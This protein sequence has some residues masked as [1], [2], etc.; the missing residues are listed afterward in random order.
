MVMYIEA[1]ESG[2]IFQN[3][4]EDDINVYAMTAANAKES[5]WGTYCSPDDKVDGKSI[6]SCLGDLFSVNFLEDIDSA[7]LG[8][9]TLQ[10]QYDTVKKKTNRSHV[11]QWGQ[12]SM[13]SEVIGE[14]EAG[15]YTKPTSLWEGFK[16]VGR[17]FANGLES[18]A[19]E[20]TQRKNDFAVDT[21]DIRL[22]H[23][24]SKVLNEPS[25]ENQ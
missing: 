2:S 1:C 21:R 10:N 11:L 23:L 17:N 24:Y 8:I 19:S 16:E 7:K 12:T 13:T 14:F 20:A 6:G 15:N 5:S 22:H 3:I 9:E 4:L 25:T 18:Y